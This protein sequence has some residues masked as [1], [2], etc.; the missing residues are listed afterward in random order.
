MSTPQQQ[1]W[2]WAGH[3]L[4]SKDLVPLGAMQ[5]QEQ[6]QLQQLRQQQQVAVNWHAVAGVGELGAWR[7]LWQQLRVNLHQEQ[8][9]EG[10]QQQV[11]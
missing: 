5:Q 11:L 2:G 4:G 6:R 9:M 10:S 3:Q 8:D 7:Q 1:Q